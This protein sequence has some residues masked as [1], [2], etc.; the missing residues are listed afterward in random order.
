MKT[1]TF[2][3]WLAK[4]GQNDIDCYQPCASCDGTGYVVEEYDEEGKYRVRCKVCAAT[5]NALYQEYL[6]QVEED[7][8][9]L[10]AWNCRNIPIV[11]VNVPQSER[12]K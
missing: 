7:K 5:G 11:E 6:R 4:T 2:Y 9:L 8:K 12:M 10:D 3:Q 1:L